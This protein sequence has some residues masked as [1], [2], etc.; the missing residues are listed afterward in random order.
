MEIWQVI[1]LMLPPTVVGRKSSLPDQRSPRHQPGRALFGAA[2]V[3]AP[4]R[5]VGGSQF[6]QVGERDLLLEQVSAPERGAPRARA[7]SRR[8]A[9]AAIRAAD[10]ARAAGADRGRQG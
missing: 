9:G 10:R 3:R 2:E 7:R 5:L 8:G 1:R 4:R 6:A